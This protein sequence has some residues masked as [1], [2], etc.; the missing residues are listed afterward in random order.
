M[1]DP[2]RI[3]RIL[4]DLRAAWLKV[5]QWRLGQLIIN[6]VDPRADCPTLFC[7]EDDKIKKKIA[8]FSR[9]L[10]KAGYPR[11]EIE[12]EEPGES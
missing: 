2:Q 1:R 9:E 10:T 11:E 3:D 4:A 6:A 5:P 12:P 7:I 8:A